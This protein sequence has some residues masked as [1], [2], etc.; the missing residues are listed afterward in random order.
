MLQFDKYFSGMGV[1][2]YVAG[3]LICDIEA[4]TAIIAKVEYKIGNIVFLKGSESS[5]KFSRGCINKRLKSQIS[6]FP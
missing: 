5:F 3:K 4:A 2:G 1:P 6:G